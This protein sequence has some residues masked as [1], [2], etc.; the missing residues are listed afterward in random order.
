MKASMLVTSDADKGISFVGAGVGFGAG[1]GL[2]AG[3]G[4]GG[5]TSLRAPRMNGLIEVDPFSVLMSQWPMPGTLF[6][7]P[8]APSENC[9][10]V[11]V[12]QG[13]GTCGAELEFEYRATQ[14]GQSKVEVRA[15]WV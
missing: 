11:H 12:F 14:S 5:L 8:Y 4:F 7:T 10:I 6:G 9:Q 13:E 3:A 1:V 2:G 15:K